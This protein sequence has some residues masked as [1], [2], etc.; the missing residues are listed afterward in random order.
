MIKLKNVKL[1]STDLEKISVQWEV[2]STSDNVFKYAFDVFRGE[3][4]NGPFDKVA[5]PLYD[6]YKVSDNIAPRKMAWRNL[7]YVVRATNVD[8][9]FTESEPKSLNARLPFEAL[10]M[11]RLQGLLLREY[12][13]RPC[14]VYPKRTFG[15]R[16]TCFDTLTQ[17]RQVTSCYTCYN[18][19]FI[20]GYHYPLMS[21]IA[22]G[23][24]SKE[25]GVSESLIMNSA[26]VHAI[27]G[28]DPIV[29]SGDIVVEREGTRWRVQSVFTTERL[30]AP[31]HQEVDLVKI[32]EGDIEFK[33]PI[34]WPE[35]VETSPR[36]FSPKMDIGD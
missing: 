18:T 25:K 2:E 34:S 15:Q 36:S 19:G 27:M 9:S 20:K 3:S 31:V 8:G 11:I 13:G 12:I 23:A 6:T 28:I 22:I 21:Y 7:Y 29:K 1:E 30:R 33:L 14:I 4:I 26:H 35:G 32:S 24:F 10:E 16:C 5:G 17:R